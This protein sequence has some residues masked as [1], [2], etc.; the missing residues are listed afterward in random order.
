MIFA[1]SD[2]DWSDY[3]E[4][5]PARKQRYERL[6]DEILE[7]LVPI[8]QR[9]AKGKPGRK[10]FTINVMV[11]PGLFAVGIT[12][13]QRT[14]APIVALT[15]DRFPG[16][17][18]LQALSTDITNSLPVNRVIYNTT[19]RVVCVGDVQFIVPTRKKKG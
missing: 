12:G 1:T 7:A 3:P 2:R 14:Y 16:Y 9:H 4:L 5:S 8:L 6:L 10:P 18:R 15:F 11:S 13:D 19:R 17:N